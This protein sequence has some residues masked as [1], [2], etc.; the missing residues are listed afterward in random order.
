[1]EYNGMGHYGLTGQGTGAEAAWDLVIRSD[2]AGILKSKPIL[3]LVELVD[4]PSNELLVKGIFTTHRGDS[5]PLVDARIPL[6][7]S[8]AGKP[9]NA[10]ALI[11]DVEGMEVGLIIGDVMTA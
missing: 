1:M 11:V 8:L 10:C 4:V 9:A 6:S 7:F 2:P 3:D 5:V